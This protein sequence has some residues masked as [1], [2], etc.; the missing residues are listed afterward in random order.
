MVAKLKRYKQREFYTMKCGTFTKVWSYE[1]LIGYVSG[2]RFYTWAYGRYSSTTSK[3][4]TMFARENGYTIIKDSEENI[5][6]KF[7]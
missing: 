1:T 2:K 7:N 5:R 4:I 6:Q 3:Q